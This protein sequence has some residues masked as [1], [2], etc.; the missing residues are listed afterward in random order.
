VAARRSSLRRLSA[1]HLGPEMPDLR[2]G[3]AASPKP[4]R[5]HPTTGYL[6]DVEFAAWLAAVPCVSSG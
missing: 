5:L 2:H 1:R 4:A 3:A 6:I